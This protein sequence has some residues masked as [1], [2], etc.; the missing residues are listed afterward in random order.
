[1]Y[2]LLLFSLLHAAEPAYYSMNQITDE[3]VLFLRSAEYSAPKMQT[4]QS[5]MRVHNKS[6][7]ELSLNAEL[8]G[9]TDPEHWAQQHR[10]TVKRYFYESEYFLQ[11]IQNDYIVAYTQSM[12]GVLAGYTNYDLIEC[13]ISRVDQMAGKKSTCVGLNITGEIAK[14]MDADPTLKETIIQIEERVW[15]EASWES[16]QRDLVPFTGT[17]YGISPSYL[18]QQLAPD[19][20]QTIQTKFDDQISSIELD[21]DRDD[22]EAITKA[23]AFRSE[24]EKSLQVLHAQLSLAAQLAFNKAGKKDG[25]WLEVGYCPQPANFGGCSAE[26]ISSEALTLIQSNKKAMKL[27]K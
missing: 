26:D 11:Q 23:K 8:L 24:Y 20:L 21:I 25:R 3:S 7:I 16:T 27:I 10:A 14:G 13:S 12:D 1:M 17:K 2:N 6:L 19:E 18:A 22:P 4:L 5:K 15:P 9:L